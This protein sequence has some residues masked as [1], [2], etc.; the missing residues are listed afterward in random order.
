MIA[1]ILAFAVV[2]GA[3]MVVSLHASVRRVRRRCPACRQL[4]LRWT[5]GGLA[6]NVD[7]GGRRFPSSHSEYRCEACHAVFFEQNRKGL[8]SKEAWQAGARE[9]IPPARVIE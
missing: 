8:V 2:C 3:G 1:T 7:A 9:P 4:Q 6:T 5:G